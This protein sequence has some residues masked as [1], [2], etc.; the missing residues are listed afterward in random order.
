M[1]KM[2]IPVQI[3]FFYVNNVQMSS[4]QLWMYVLIMFKVRQEAWVMFMFR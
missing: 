3:S 4:K 1:L 2:I